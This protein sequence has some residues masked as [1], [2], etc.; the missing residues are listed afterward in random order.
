MIIDMHIHQKLNSSDSKLDLFEAIQVAKTRGLDAICITDHDDLGLKPMAETVSRETGFPV[1]VGVEIYTLD[2]DLLCFG[3]DEMPEQRMSAQETIDYV[4][5]RGGVT[6]AAHPYRNNNRGLGDVIAEVKGLGAIEAFN[7]RTDSFSNLKARNLAFALNM[8]LSG[9]SDAHTD[10]EV[11][12][13][14]TK[15]NTPVNSEADLISAIRN[16]LIEP[17]SMTGR[18][19]QSI[20]TA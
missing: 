8:P 20:E 1:Y 19:M 17:I 4:N 6:I 18:E 16:G 2:G 11:G 13:Y 7:G 9:G 5:E 3:I 10:G 12:H 15:F 14:A